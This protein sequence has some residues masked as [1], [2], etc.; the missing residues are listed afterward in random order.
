MAKVKILTTTSTD[1][2]VENPYIYWLK[3][4]NSITT[5]EYT[6]VVFDNIKHAVLIGSSNFTLV[7]ECL[8]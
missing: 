2:N 3:C 4:K 8:E 5:F 1:K 6:L 7:H